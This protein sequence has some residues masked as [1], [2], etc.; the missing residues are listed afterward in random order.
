MARYLQP[1]AATLAAVLITIA[2]FASAASL[3]SRAAAVSA[4]PLLA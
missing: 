4:A 1:T 3:P 2:T